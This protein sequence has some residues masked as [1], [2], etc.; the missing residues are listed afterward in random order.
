[1]TGI[2]YR[3]L[4]PEGSFYAFP[5]TPLADDVAFVR[6]LAEEGVLTVPGT[7]FGC[8]GHMRISFTVE[9]DTIVR[10]MPGFARAFER[11]HAAR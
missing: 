11:A 3:C 9:R 8:P 6:L 1:L 5:E 10:S 7:G 2:G 4:R